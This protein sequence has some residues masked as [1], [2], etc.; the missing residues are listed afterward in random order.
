MPELTAEQKEHLKIARRSRIRIEET[1]QL[2]CMYLSD[3]KTPDDA[4]EKA[5]AAVSVWADWMDDAE[6]EPPDIEQP[7]F[8]SQMGEAVG[9][10]MQHIKTN[11]TGAGELRIGVDSESNTGV[12]ADFLPVEH[13]PEHPAPRPRP[14]KT[15]WNR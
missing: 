2:F 5:R 4:L 11:P 12:D 6:I 1:W 13:E 10:M 9:K 7:D 14:P 8:V 15:L 3:N